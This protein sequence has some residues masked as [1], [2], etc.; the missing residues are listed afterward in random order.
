MIC[1]VRQYRLP[2]KPSAA[3]SPS[4]SPSS[5]EDKDIMKVATLVAWIESLQKLN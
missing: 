4:P 1:V 3:P 5:F 2:M